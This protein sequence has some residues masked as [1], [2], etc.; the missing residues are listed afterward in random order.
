M[1]GGYG[2]KERPSY[3]GV[4]FY[5]DFAFHHLFHKIKNVENTI[6]IISNIDAGKRFAVI[7]FDSNI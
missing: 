6:P 5:H 3:D 7:A 4:F 2:S 1:F